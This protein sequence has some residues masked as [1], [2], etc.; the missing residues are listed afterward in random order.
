M[1]FHLAL[2]EHQAY[3]MHLPTLQPAIEA[4]GQCLLQTFRQGHKLLLCGNGGSAADCQH[5]AAE[6]VVRYR[7]VRAALPAIALTTDTSIL[8]AHPNDFSF[9]TVFERQVAALGQTGDCLLA[10]STSGNSPNIIAAVQQARRQHLHTIVLSGHE[11]G[12]LAGMAEHDIIIPGSVTARIQ[13]M[14]I[15]I[16]HWW[17]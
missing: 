8:T 9:D 6:F 16:A 2:Q 4:A 10:I 7:K 14:H 13:E 12:R 15:L 1:S 3:L 17:C 11:G 5:I